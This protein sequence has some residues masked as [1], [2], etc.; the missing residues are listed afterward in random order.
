[1]RKIRGHP[2]FAHALYASARAR[3]TDIPETN[4]RSTQPGSKLPYPPP[5]PAVELTLYTPTGLYQR[6]I[7]LSPEAACQLADELRAAAADAH[8]GR[9]A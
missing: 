4:G 6:A 9:T 5:M 2:Q 3:L 1:M 7:R 8:A